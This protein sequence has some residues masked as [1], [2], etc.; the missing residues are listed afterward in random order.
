VLSHQF[1]PVEE[2][3]PGM[4]AAAGAIKAV[5]EDPL[6]PVLKLDACET[7][8]PGNFGDPG[9]DDDPA[10]PGPEI[11]VKHFVSHPQ[12]RMP[13]DAPLARRNALFPRE[14]GIEANFLRKPF[15]GADSFGTVFIIPHRLKNLQPS[16]TQT[17]V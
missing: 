1:N 6:F 7:Q 16:W 5:I 4:V 17:P 13:L 14:T 9:F 11:L 3:D 8:P 10:P 2:D 15:Q 12:V